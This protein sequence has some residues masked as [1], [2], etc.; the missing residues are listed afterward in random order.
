[1][2]SRKVSVQSMRLSFERSR[3]GI[4]RKYTIAA[5]TRN[6]IA[7]KISANASWSTLNA[8]MMSSSPRTVASPASNEKMIDAIGNV[9]YVAASD[10]EFADESCSS[11]TRFGTDAACAGP[12]SSVRISRPSE[13]SRRP[14]M[15][16]DERQADEQAGPA[17]VAQHHHLAAVEAVDDH[18]AD[19]AE[20]EARAA[21]GSS[22]PG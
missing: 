17:D 18:A 12:Q 1:M 16:F 14:A 10:S 21:R 2:I 3:R 6:V 9:P 20:Q 15:P 5:D 13:M 22:S 7:S 4:G 19:G 11:C 8:E